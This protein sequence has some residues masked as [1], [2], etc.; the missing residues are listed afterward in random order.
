M[1]H[2]IQWVFEW[3]KMELSENLAETPNPNGLP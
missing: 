2:A 3:E 1:F